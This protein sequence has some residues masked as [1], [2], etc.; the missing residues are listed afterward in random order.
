[1]RFHVLTNIDRISYTA[2]N[3]APPSDA[4]VVEPPAPVAAMEETRV[5]ETNMEPS[6]PKQ[7]TLDEV[8]A[9]RARGETSAQP[10]SS[11]IELT[12]RTPDTAATDTS[13]APAPSQQNKK[14]FLSRLRDKLGIA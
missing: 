14:G 6:A 12:S 2:N 1:M 7:M 9:K 11:S 10:T 3:A 8:L 5:V 4:A 13:Q